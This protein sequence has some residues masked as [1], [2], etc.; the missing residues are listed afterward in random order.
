MYRGVFSG[1]LACLCVAAPAAAQSL[2]FEEAAARAREQAGRVLVARARVAEA[3]AVLVDASARYRTNPALDVSA[4]PRFAA[5]GKT[6]D[7][8]I[9]LSQQFDS[10]AQRTA[11]MAAA[12]AGIDRERASAGEASRVAVFDALSAFLDAVA[13]R[14]RLRLVEE[15]E[16]VSRQ[17][18]SATDRRYAAGDVSGIDLNHARIEAARAAST[19]AASR[20]A[21]ADALQQL[22]GLLRLATLDAVEGT[23]DV[24]PP[25]AVATARASLE[26]RPDL[27]ALTAEARAAEAEAQLGQAL[28]RPELGAKVGYQR[29]ENDSVVLGGLTITLPAFQRGQ[30]LIAAGR[31]RATRA[32]LEFETVRDLAAAELDRAYTAYANQAQAAALLDAA[33]P[34]VDD[35]ENLARRS[36]EAGEMGLLDYLIIRR[37]AL[38]T[39]TAAVDRRL[40]VARSRLLIDFVAGVLR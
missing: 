9:A 18:M 36:Y 7:L 31:A 13:A 12:R 27:A 26:Q 33:L 39:R 11:R 22:R 15:S 5:A 25:P 23:L 29:D 8:D 16:G 19:L 35:N 38:Q 6:A 30:G 21:A 4:G 40:A 34:S 10:R 1:A 17:L 3:E 24:A 32:R 20:A 2:T 28:A 37:D 14:D